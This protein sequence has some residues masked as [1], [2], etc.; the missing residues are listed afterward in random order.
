MK[1]LQ[2]HNFVRFRGG[3]EQVFLSTTE[4][5]RKN[6]INV[7][8]L[9]ADSQGLDKNI[10]CK[11]RAFV[12]GIYSIYGYQS[13]L[14]HL[15]KESPDIVHVHHLYP[16]LSPSVLS[17]CKEKNVPVVMSCHNYFLECP[18]GFLLS[19]GKICE[20]CCEGKEYWCILKN[21]RDNIFESTAYA[22]RMAIARCL[23]LFNNN[24]TIYIALSNFAKKRLIKSGIAENR[25]VVLPNMVPIPDYN[26]ENI[27]RGYIAYVGRIF[28]EKG[29]D[30]LMEAA[31][32]TGLPIKI[33]G[34][35]NHMPHLLNTAP[36][37][38][39][40][41]GLLNREQLTKFYQEAR[42]LIVP[43]KWYEMCPLVI[44][45]A[46]SYGLSVITS[47]LGALPEL[48]EHN[49]TGFVF[50]PG[51]SIELAQMMSFL[52][53]NIDLSTKMGKAGFEKAQRE[54]SEETYLNRLLAIYDEAISFN[55]HRTDR[56]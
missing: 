6:G 36:P 28:P 35:C 44:S 47:R 26:T 22:I 46:M 53:D 39:V 49:I 30:T 33:A 4:L 25:I 50:D 52:W 17:A 15:D 20:K 1:V 23:N 16:L 9:A 51:N 12:N 38:V 8:I 48:V 43:S 24:V 19:D 32:L 56:I 29:V 31:R 11:F 45:E 7:T 3:M 2:V 10:L 21:C 13:M 40:F 5:L 37:N 55:S 34:D 27:D 54:Y 41:V 14:Q 42:F 18:I